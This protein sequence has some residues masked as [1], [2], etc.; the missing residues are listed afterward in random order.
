VPVGL[1]AGLAAPAVEETAAWRLLEGDGEILWASGDF[2]VLAGP[3]GWVASAALGCA[4]QLACQ[5][6]DRVVGGER[7]EKMT[8][9]MRRKPKRGGA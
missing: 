3:L 2:P 9:L 5:R 8:G 6:W 4:G 7:R 1:A